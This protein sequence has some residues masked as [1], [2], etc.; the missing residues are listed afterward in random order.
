[1]AVA[2]VVA[3]TVLPVLTGTPASAQITWNLPS[4]YPADNF[5]TQNLDAFAADV[6]QVTNG[7]LAIR[8][9][10]NASLLPASAIKS[11]VRIG[12]VQ[13]AETLISLHEH[14]DP[15]FGVDAVPFLA[16]S[17]DEARKLWAA[18]KPTIARIFAAQ[19][20]I[21]LFAVPWPPQG[22]FANQEINHI[23]DLRGLSWRVYNAG[24]R[25]LAQI[26]EAH[27]VTIQAAD[28]RKALS[29]GLIQ[30]LMT[31]AATGYD[32]EVWD[33]M[34][35][36]YD[37]RAW[38]P[39]NVTLMNRAAFEQ[40]EKPMQDAVL[41]VAEAAEA[42]G[43]WWSQDKTKWYTEQLAAHGMKVLAPSVALKTALQKI[44][45]QLTAEWLMRAGA[46]GLAMIEAYRS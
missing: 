41:K 20:L 38:I 1:L 23:G 19:G 32:V 34:A 15:I 9:Y 11:A 7:K 21:V 17:Y 6:A 29:T 14:E 39:K 44:G 35:Y 2:A 30:A 18:S 46:D 13:I 5:H 24:T 12:Q 22:I 8:V 3:L 36:F 37:T 4:A 40:L 33:R 43:W 27:P 45:E 42:R 26:V 25:R 28:L 31:S 16:N 10:P